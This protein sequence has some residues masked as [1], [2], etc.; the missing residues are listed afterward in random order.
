[1]NNNELD[2]L[3]AGRQGNQHP[4]QYQD[5]DQDI[6]FPSASN[7]GIGAI[8]MNHAS[9]KDKLLGSGMNVSD[10][11][12]RMP[13]STANEEIFPEKKVHNHTVAKKRR[14]LSVSRRFSHET[15]SQIQIG[16]EKKKK[17]TK[18]TGAEEAK[19]LSEI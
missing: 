7:K 12:N 6:P 18:T 13:N 4:S 5:A 15:K 3:N 8:N 14:K 17:E 19:I 9:A 10:S 16:K 11:N 1:M 2:R